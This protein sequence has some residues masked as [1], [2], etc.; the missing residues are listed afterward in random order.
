M[1]LLSLCASPPSTHQNVLSATRPPR[2]VLVSALH[3]SQP[4]RFVPLFSFPRCRCLRPLDVVSRRR[5]PDPI[6]PFGLRF[7]DLERL[8]ISRALRHRAAARIRPH[9]CLP[10]SRRL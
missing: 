5:L 6:P 7:D 4:S 3:E 1:S 10:A 8:G 9:V 2:V